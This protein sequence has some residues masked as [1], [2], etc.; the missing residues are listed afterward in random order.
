MLLYNTYCAVTYFY[1]VHKCIF[2]AKIT[3]KLLHDCGF[4]YFGNSGSSQQCFKCHAISVSQNVCEDTQLVTFTT[5][6]KNETL[7][8]CLNLFFRAFQAINLGETTV[9]K[10]FLRSALLLGNPWQHWSRRT[11]RPSSRGCSLSALWKAPPP[12]KDFI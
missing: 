6:P 11:S 1:K 4:I 5:R 9:Y 7:L 10:W 12:K 8:G 3:Y 2:T